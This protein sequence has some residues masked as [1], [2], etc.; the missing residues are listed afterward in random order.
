MVTLRSVAL[1]AISMG[2]ETEGTAL[3]Y[4][5]AT[6]LHTERYV[7]CLHLLDPIIFLSR[8][9]HTLPSF[10]RGNSRPR[11]S[12][13]EMQSTRSGSI[14]IDFGDP[15]LEPCHPRNI[16]SLLTSAGSCRN[17]AQLA[18]GRLIG[19]LM[20]GLRRVWH[21][22]LCKQKCLCMLD[23]FWAMSHAWAL[24]GLFTKRAKAKI[25]QMNCRCILRETSSRSLTLQS[26]NVPG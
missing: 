7:E 18:E 14:I 13:T 2:K 16:Y 3:W 22:L 23:T 25:S 9:F 8:A 1:H 21:I 12:A 4:K 19:S 15:V 10:P 6:L 5:Y 20:G 11:L 24:F 26:P 17:A